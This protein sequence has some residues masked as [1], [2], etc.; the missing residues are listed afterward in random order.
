M[1]TNELLN[2]A[3]YAGKLLIESGAEIY[4]V[5]ETMVR[6]CTSFPE[7]EEAHSF[8]TPTGIMFSI[9][10]NKTISTKILRV[11]SRGVDLNCID[12][13]NHLSR[14]AATQKFSIAQLNA[15]L[16]QIANEDRYRFSIIL[17]F[18]AL[19][20]GG[21]AIF[22]KGSILDAGC[23]FLIGLVIKT[24]SWLMEKRSMHTFFV[25]AIAGGVAAV[26]AIVLYR[27]APAINLDILIV[28]SIM[29]LVPGLAITNAIR[30]TV[31]GDYLSGVAR[32][33][34]AFLVAVAIAV[35]IGFVLS[36]SIGIHGG[37]T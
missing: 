18:G 29:L 17:F 7:V 33:T 19:S 20:A 34:E 28:S 4:R 30:D 12:K 8:A 2:M 14:D 24:L 3:C 21:F 15:R 35:G 26:F 1:N 16:V 25:N 10:V 9:T 27:L 31:A 13:I 22:F 6:L 37:T 36:M 5:E 11:R 23:S 32:A